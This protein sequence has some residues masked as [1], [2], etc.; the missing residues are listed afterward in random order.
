M[1]GKVSAAN[2]ATIAMTLN[3]SMRV[4][5]AICAE[6]LKLEAL[7]GGRPLGLI[8]VESGRWLTLEWG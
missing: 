1:N 2:R 4:N 8:E 5:P 7:L 3:N 6:L